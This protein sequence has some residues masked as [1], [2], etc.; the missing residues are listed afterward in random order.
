MSR[1][2]RESSIGVRLGWLA[3]TPDL[4]DRILRN[5]TSIEN[6]HKLRKKTF[7]FLLFIEV[8]QT[9]SFPFSLLR[10]YEMPECFYVNN[11]CF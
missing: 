10:H 6:A 4:Q 5:Y 11:C 2:I 8:Q 9:F 7:V 3:H 1:R